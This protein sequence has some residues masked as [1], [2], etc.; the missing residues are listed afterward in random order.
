MRIKPINQTYFYF[1]L[2]SF[3]ALVLLMIIV[4]WELIAV[5][6]VYQEAGMSCKTCGLTRAFNSFLNGNFQFSWSHL[7]EI[8]IILFFCLQFLARG[9]L[10]AWLFFSEQHKTVLY[11]DCV[12]SSTFFVYA[13]Y[14]LFLL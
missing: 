5:K 1:N 8:K 4:K 11:A 12:V 2:I 9:F 14:E 7:F 3:T 13:F 6:C 10:T